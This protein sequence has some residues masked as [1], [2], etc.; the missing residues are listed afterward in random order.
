MIRHGEQY[1]MTAQ[2][3]VVALQAGFYRGFHPMH[4]QRPPQLLWDALTQASPLSK[5]WSPLGGNPVQPHTS[6]PHSALLGQVL[7]VRYLIHEEVPQTPPDDHLD[8]WNARERI[9]R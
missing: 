6:P 4:L 1:R 2:T 9:N 3:S 7:T 8:V 5:Q